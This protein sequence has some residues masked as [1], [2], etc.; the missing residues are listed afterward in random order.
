M[1]MK[2]NK[3]AVLRVVFALGGLVL[4]IASMLY[5]GEHNWFLPFGLL[6]VSVASMINSLEGKNK[7]K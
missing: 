3:Y 4:I 7:E 1:V 5:E 6:L 2:F